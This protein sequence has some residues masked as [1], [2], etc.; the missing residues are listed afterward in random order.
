M[1][2]SSKEQGGR[3]DLV[4]RPDAE[5]T[6]DFEANGDIIGRWGA[7]LLHL[8][9]S[10]C[11]LPLGYDWA[12][13][14]DGR[15]SPHVRSRS[16][17]T[18]HKALPW[19]HLG[20]V[21]HWIVPRAEDR[22]DLIAFLGTWGERFAFGDGVEANFPGY[23][24]LRTEP[25][26]RAQDLWE[27]GIA[28][29][30]G[31]ESDGKRVRF[32]ELDARFR[33]SPGQLELKACDDA[34]PFARVRVCVPESPAL[35]CWW[36]VELRVPSG[37]RLFIET[38]HLLKR[39]TVPPLD[40][41]EPIDTL[42]A[43]FGFGNFEDGLLEPMLQDRSLTFRSSE[44]ELDAELIVE[45]EE[46][47]QFRWAPVDAFCAERAQV[48]GLDRS[49][50]AAFD[51]VTE[52]PLKSSPEVQTVRVGLRG[53]RTEAAPSAPPSF[54]RVWEDSAVDASGEHPLVF[55]SGDIHVDGYFRWAT[56][57]L[58][59]LVWPNGVL[60]TGALGYLGKSHVGQD[61]PLVYPSL[62]YHEHPR[63]QAAARRNL[64][65]LWASPRRGENRGIIDHPA[66]GFDFAFVPFDPRQA[67]FWKS[68]GAVGL[69]RQIDGL[70]RY[71]DWT[72]DRARVDRY[73]EIATEV[74][75]EHYHPFDPDAPLWL[76]GEETQNASYLVA[77]APGCLER[78]ARGLDARSVSARAESVR[79][80][81]RVIRELANRPR[82]QGGFLEEAD[83]VAPDGRRIPGGLLIPRG[84]DDSE[85][86]MFSYDILLVNAVALLNRALEPAAAARVIEVLLDP[87]NPWL[88]PEAGFAK[89]VGGGR[90]VW[91]W[92]NSLIAQALLEVE[93]ERQSAARSLAW[94]LLQWM[95]RAVVD[96][97]GIGIP[98]EETMGGD[99]AMAVGC[100]GITTLIEGLL[101]ASVV[102]GSLTLR[103]R[104]PDE[105]AELRVENLLFRG[106]RW[107]V[108]C[109]PSGVT[110]HAS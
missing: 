10:T 90:G 29:E 69:L 31:V 110:R 20:Y 42:R 13:G 81:A 98:G 57:V 38:R 99:Y 78:F 11:R 74:Y 32:S 97:N 86:W 43:P 22:C 47:P 27:D 26:K 18:G 82:S 56:D 68:E 91:F 8:H 79:A 33:R 53:H 28:L 96:F 6:S 40:F 89:T 108:Q 76:A 100:L 80:D 12:R 35:S 66:D 59:S 94:R 58:V 52:I 45:S 85:S 21:P 87:Q 71:G 41:Q 14:D 62:L 50:A 77:T 84:T 25:R 72:G 54:R 49:R 3:R 92:H 37:G 2:G 7:G 46:P 1:S 63:L 102:D 107:D 88:V 15:W 106:Q 44:V 65:F 16:L 30:L 23:G 73:L 61:I 105:V 103:P 39:L 67:R 75:F 101:G 64:D 70:M 9:S 95:G 55:R 83:Q 93:G 24:I 104:L 36:E 19:M 17:V 4:P 109:D 48:L 51:V 5:T 34:S 60:T